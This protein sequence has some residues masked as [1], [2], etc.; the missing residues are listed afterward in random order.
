MCIHFEVHN[1][2]SLNRTHF[3]ATIN[4]FFIYIYFCVREKPITR[5]G[6]IFGRCRLCDPHSLWTCFFPFVCVCKWMHRPPPLPPKS[7]CW[8]WKLKY[9]IVICCELFVIIRKINQF[10]HVRKF[11]WRISTLFTIELFQQTTTSKA[12]AAVMTFLCAYCSYST[13]KKKRPIRTNQPTAPIRKCTHIHVPQKQKIEITFLFMK[14]KQNVSRFKRGQASRKLFVHFSSSVSPLSF[15]FAHFSLRLSRSFYF[16]LS[17]VVLRYFSEITTAF[18]IFTVHTHSNIKYCC[19]VTDNSVFICNS[20]HKIF[21]V[22]IFVP[23]LK[24]P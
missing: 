2:H 16:S 4:F 10:H 19:W 9:W 12:A 20:V 24:L 6:C 23:L 22:C 18:S 7:E 8:N 13:R 14:P 11:F 21:G 1:C 15:H 3:P 17:L 5:V